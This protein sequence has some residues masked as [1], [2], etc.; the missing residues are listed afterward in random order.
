[1]PRAEL[2]SMYNDMVYA[3]DYF[4]TQG[5]AVEYVKDRHQDAD[6]NILWA[7]WLT[8]DARACEPHQDSAMHI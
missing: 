3:Y 5:T 2:N 6:L 7:M 4:D 8:L 1:M